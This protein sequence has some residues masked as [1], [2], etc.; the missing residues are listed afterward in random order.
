MDISGHQTRAT[1]DRYNITSEKDL[2]EAL[3]KTS[4]YVEGLPSAHR[5]PNPSSSS[6]HL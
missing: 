5:K 6:C 2:R 1:F 4:A 3:V